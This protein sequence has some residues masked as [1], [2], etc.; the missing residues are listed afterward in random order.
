M[1]CTS[2]KYDELMRSQAEDFLA[3]LYAV[4]GGN[5]TQKTICYTAFY[6]C[7]SPFFSIYVNKNPSFGSEIR[8]YVIKGHT[9]GLL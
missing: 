8:F 1:G 7:P 3:Y 6:L 9:F 5:F 4:L 2:K